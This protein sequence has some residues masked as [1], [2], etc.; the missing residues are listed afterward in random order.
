MPRQPRCR[1][2]P[3]AE[4]AA[5]DL[6]VD[7]EPAAADAALARQLHQTASR[8]VSLSQELVLRDCCFKWKQ[9]APPAAGCCTTNMAQAYCH[10]EC[11]HALYSTPDSALHRLRCEVPFIMRCSKGVVKPFVHHDMPLSSVIPEA[12][13]LT[14]WYCKH[15]H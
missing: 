6:Q 11:C 8:H 1:L 9:G 2:Q 12:C 3:V 5:V 13:F 14:C 10:S 7:T 15:K 4:A